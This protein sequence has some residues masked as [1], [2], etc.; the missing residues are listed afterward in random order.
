MSHFFQKSGKSGSIPSVLHIEILRD[1][2]TFVS[3]IFRNSSFTEL[4]KRNYTW[5]ESSQNTSFKI[6]LVSESVKDSDWFPTQHPN[7]HDLI[8]V[9]NWRTMRVTFQTR[10]K[11][12]PT[13][14]GPKRYPYSA[15]RETAYGWETEEVRVFPIVV[16]TEKVFKGDWYREGKEMRKVWMTDVI[17]EPGTLYDMK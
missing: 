17:N 6:Q 9:L 15:P 16:P 12:G 3:R 4:T 1:W 13:S 14:Q 8:F 7:L 5:K 2:T 11:K 10:H